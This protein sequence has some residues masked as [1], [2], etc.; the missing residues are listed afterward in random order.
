MALNFNDVLSKGA[1]DVE[2]PALPPVGTYRFRISKVPEQTESG[3]GEWDIVNF[4]VQAVEALDNVDVD[5]Y[6]GE[7]S[8]I[9]LRKSFLFNKGDEAEF[10][11]TFYNLKTFLANHVKCWPDDISLAEA[12]NASNGQEFLGDVTWAEDKREPGEFQANIGRTAPLD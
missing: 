2:K 7:I 11:R 3:S 4:Q 5:D 6:K 10:N 8:N 9:R 12:L 1:A